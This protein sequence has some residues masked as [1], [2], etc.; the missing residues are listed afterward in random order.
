M[1]MKKMIK[2]LLAGLSLISVNV[3]AATIDGSLIA[4]GA[5][6]TT[7]GVNLADATNVSLGTVFANGGTG[8]VEGTVNGSTLAGTGGALSLNAF[9][10]VTNFFSVG[11]WTLD[12]STLTIVDQTA[13]LL[14]L[15]GL[16]VLTGHGFDATDVNWSFS[17]SSTTSYSMTVS[18]VS[19]VPVPA[20]AWLF[21]SGLLGLVG[22]ARRKA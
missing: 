6:T 1:K 8:D 20:A 5:Y 4:G 13:G 14:N 10:P 18:S 2:V 11:G 3:F 22:V 19:P 21:G 9:A 12:V 7:G 15:S 17:S 16:G